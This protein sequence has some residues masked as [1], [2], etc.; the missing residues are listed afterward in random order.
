MLNV[1]E[2][3][4]FFFDIVKITPKS[5]NIFFNIFFLSHIKWASIQNSYL[6]LLDYLLN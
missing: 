4:M 5:K 3:N 2:K 6:I 1:N